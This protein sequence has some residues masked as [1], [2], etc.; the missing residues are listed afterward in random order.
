MTETSYATIQIVAQADVIATELSEHY[1]NL[2]GKRQ[3]AAYDNA[4]SCTDE[5]ARLASSLWQYKED[6]LNKTVI[7]QVMD[8]IM[9]SAEALYDILGYEVDRIRNNEQ[10]ASVNRAMAAVEKLVFTADT[11]T[12]EAE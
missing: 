10:K 11:L 9:A 12:R 5:I 8:S 2:R 6:E 4:L 3:Q 1:D 7:T